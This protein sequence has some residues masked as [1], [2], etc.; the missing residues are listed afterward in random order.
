MARFAGQPILT[1]GASLHL[2]PLSFINGFSRFRFGGQYKWSRW[3]V[4][5]DLETGSDFTQGLVGNRTQA[6]YSFRGVRPELRYFPPSLTT[7]AYFGLELPFT[8]LRR[9]VDGR[10]EGRDG[11][12]MQ[13]SNT[14]Q[15]RW[16]A[17]LLIKGGIQFA[18]WQRMMIDVYLGVGAAYREVAYVG[19]TTI[20]PLDLLT[21]DWFFWGLS[22][23]GTRWVGDLAAG[24]R[25]GYWFGNRQ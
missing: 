14:L 25:I 6:N 19:G 12:L 4:L 16:R 2:M 18:V 15:E 8:H 10:F 24:F 23:E 17:G 3:S 5:L 21:D 11:Q 1:Q 20:A 22:N 13:A 7:D 9:R